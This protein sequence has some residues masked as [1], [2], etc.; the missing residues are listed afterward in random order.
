MQQTMAELTGAV[1][2]DSA[3]HNVGREVCVG[4]GSEAARDHLHHLH[5]LR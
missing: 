5:D 1:L 3:L 2:C 4:C